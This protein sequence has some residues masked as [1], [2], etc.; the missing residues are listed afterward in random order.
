MAFGDWEG[1]DPDKIHEQQDLIQK[2][3]ENIAK[4]LSED[5]KTNMESRLKEYWASL[6]ANEKVQ[7]FY[8]NAKTLLDTVITENFKQLFQA[9]NQCAQN[10]ATLEKSTRWEDKELIVQDINLKA[11]M[12]D[13]LDGR[14]GCDGVQCETIITEA[15]ETL[16]SDLKT[17]FENAREHVD[18]CGFID[19]Q[20]LQMNAVKND[21]TELE[22][23]TNQSVEAFKDSLIT[24]MQEVHKAHGDL[25]S[26]NST[27][28]A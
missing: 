9:I 11:D 18:D 21:I 16:G 27:R 5:L 3:Y 25:V 14:E 10:W 22:T 24:G 17:Y 7:A 1:F 28:T 23:S 2:E 4:S 12:P 19:A 8:D 26:A 13:Q 20:A 15:M 6:D